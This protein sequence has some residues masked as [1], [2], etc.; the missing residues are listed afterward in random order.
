MGLRSNCVNISKLPGIIPGPSA[1]Q[2]TVVNIMRQWGRM[3]KNKVLD[4]GSKSFPF[5]LC[6]SGQ[7][8]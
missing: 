8:P 6:D 5:Q 7:V 3:L 1:K 2:V 4:L